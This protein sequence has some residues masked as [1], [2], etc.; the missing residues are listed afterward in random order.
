MAGQS[1]P[2][3]HRGTRQFRSFFEGKMAWH[4][5]ERFFAQHSIFSQHSVEIGAEPVGQ[6]FRPNWAAKPTRMETASDPVAH[7]DP[8]HPGADRSDFAGT[9][10]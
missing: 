4:A 9:V 1:D 8:H 10:G 7:L 6:V 3:S 2:G 5:N